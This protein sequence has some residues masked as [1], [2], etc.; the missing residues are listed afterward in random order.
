MKN[1]KKQREIYIFP[2]IENEIYA[3]FC[4][5]FHSCSP[6]VPYGLSVIYRFCLAFWV[7]TLC[8]GRSTVFRAAKQ[9]YNF[10]HT[11]WKA[12]A[13]PF[14]AI[15]RLQT[16]CAC[17]CWRNFRNGLAPS[18]ETQRVG[19]SQTRTATGNAF[20]SKPNATNIR[21]RLVCSLYCHALGCH[22]LV[23]LHIRCHAL[24]THPY[25]PNWSNALA[26]TTIIFICMDEFGSFPPNTAEIT[27]SVQQS[28]Q[29]HDEKRK[30]NQ[31]DGTRRTSNKSTGP[32]YNNRLIADGHLNCHE[33]ANAHTYISER[34]IHGW[35][36]GE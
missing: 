2:K 6:I 25:F 16:V 15:A 22:P 26:A 36:S 32:I 4:L 7:L 3:N 28:N 11:S 12:N 31:S 14:H 5:F 20:H 13:M 10:L 34:C 19:L 1:E 8:P 21:L 30:W 33:S 35:R 24:V 17:Q 23:T 18:S 27:R 9:H 29:L